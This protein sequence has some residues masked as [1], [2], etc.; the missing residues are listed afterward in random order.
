MSHP[1][2]EVKDTPWGK[3][4]TETVERL[5]KHIKDERVIDDKSTNGDRNPNGR[6]GWRLSKDIP[7]SVVGVIIMQTLIAV[8]FI[9]GL[10][11]GLSQVVKDNAESKATA[12]SKEDARHE[13]EFMEQKFLLLQN[14]DEEITRRIALLEAQLNELKLRGGK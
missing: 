9:A 11:N 3:H 12:Y 1:L 5:E 6:N 10:S 14:K 4:V 7:I 2:D 8:W 13:R